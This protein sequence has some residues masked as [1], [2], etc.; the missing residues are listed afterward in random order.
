MVVVLAGAVLLFFWRAALLKGTFFVQDVMVQNY[1][2]RDFFAR[3][4]KDFSLP[5]WCPEINYGFPLFA[6]GQAG[7][8]YPLNLLAALLLPTFAGLNYNV[9]VHLWL[10]GV[11]TYA[12]LRVLGCVRPAALTGGLTY[13]CGGFLVV[14][15]MSINYLDVCAWMPLFFLLVELAVQRRRWLY[16]LLAGG[17]VGLQF[18]A[19]HPQATVYA[20]GAGVL[21][22]VYRGVTQ[23]AGWRFLALVALGVP[24]IGAALA[25]VQLIP[26]AEL[27]WLSGRSEGVS[28]ERF[29]S[30]SLPPE[31][32]ITLLLP[33]FFGNSAT[34]SYWGREA[35]FYL[36]LCGYMGILPLLLA[37]LA[38][39]ER[40]D[41]YTSFF[42]ALCALALV[43]S[44]G[45]FT[46]LYG[47]LYAVP[48]LKFFRIP[49][50]FLLWLAF[51][52]AVLSGLGLDRVLARRGERRHLS[53][54]FLVVFLALVAGGMALLNRAVLLPEPDFLRQRW[55]AAMEHYQQD[56]QID[57]LRCG[58]MLG[59]GGLI[60]SYRGGGGRRRQ[61]MALLVPLLVFVDL[62]SFGGGFNALVDPQVYQRKP[63]SA[64]FILQDAGTAP[65]MAPRILSLV[66]EKNAPYNW[67][68]GWSRDQRSYR[69]YPETLRLYTGSVYG[70]ANVMPGWSPLHL[71]R[72]WEFVTGYPAFMS[73]AGVGYVVS[74]PPVSFTGL[75]LAFEGEVKV[76][77]NTAVLPRAYLVRNYR[78]IEDGRAR[79]QWLKGSL[80]E[81]RQQVVLEE[82]PR[83]LFEVA[84]GKE[85][86]EVDI[87]SYG[88]E[89]VEIELGEHEGGLLVLSD[90]YYPGWRAYV[91]G[92]EQKILRA[93]HVFRALAVPPT[94]QRVVFR[95]GAPSFTA[96]AWLSGAALGIF[97]LLLF[98]KRGQEIGGAGLLTLEEKGWPGA[99]TVQ[100]VLIFAIHALVTQWPQW[101][102][103]LQRSRV[104]EAWGGG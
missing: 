63:S 45:H 42:F 67:H 82:E 70:L 69:L 74:Y 31:R 101:A 33:N 7:V 52:V 51:G 41:G 3:A 20:V 24:L 50:R 35:G 21:Y 94:A 78:V 54:W 44:L 59:V 104:L 49:T 25:A 99:L 40:R 19:G 11:G 93:N 26:T 46:A 96:G 5:L 29:T 37:L 32:L 75:E 66:S 27:V 72:H 95:Y 76:Y 36:Q 91:D 38:T 48:G 14:R 80:F 68:S 81:P 100:T 30:M 10:A 2:F 56:L 58:L 65:G 97:A 28:L 9:I 103:V 1:P 88:P 47:F 62:Y 92:E 22:G 53:W 87:V 17:V 60:L 43:L 64:G 85:L 15:A 71:R 39:R 73:M 57:L 6:E 102:Q 98:W 79:L 18:L 86:E 77:R 89:E 13:A 83:T 23:K 8:L 4:L 90:T 61:G 84:V 55:G 34:G 12:F 16:L